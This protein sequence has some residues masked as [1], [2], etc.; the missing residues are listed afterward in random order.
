MSSDFNEIWYACLCGQDDVKKKIVGQIVNGLTRG[1]SDK[2][3]R[4]S[5][6][7][8]T[9]NNVLANNFLIY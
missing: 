4:F 3:G 9:P 1:G 6:Q 2:I 8:H 7:G 5:G